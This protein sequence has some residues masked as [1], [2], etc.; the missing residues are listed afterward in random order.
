[1]SFSSFDRRLSLRA[2]S[3]VALAGALAVF[4][5]APAAAETRVRA[6]YQL[7][8]AGFEIGA[9]SMQSGVDGSGYDINLSLRMTGLARFITGGRGAAT[10]RGALHDAAVTPAAYALNTRSSDKGQVI[11]F[12]L[13]AGAITQISVEP[14]PK[15]RDTVPITDADKRGVIDPLSALVM[16]VA[17]SGDPLAPSSCDRTLPIFDG[18]QRFDVTL[19]YDRFETAKGD[20]AVKGS[21]DGKVIVCKASYK[22]IAGHKPGRRQV[23]FMENNKDMEVWLAPIAGTRALLPWKIS[24]R[25]EMGTAVIAA[26][27][28]VVDGDAKAPGEKSNL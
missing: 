12:A 19:R 4:S 10:S 21:Y 7:T 24:V 27:S 20:P 13:A 2:A 6:R 11:R 5:A 22:A 26:T 17:G 1:M 23:T 16:P 28:F 15:T 25:T 3:A 14:P 8:L 9:A 18:R